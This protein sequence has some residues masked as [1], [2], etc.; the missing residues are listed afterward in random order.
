MVYV[1]TNLGILTT[2]SEGYNQGTTKMWEVE[3]YGMTLIILETLE[4]YHY[5]LMN[6]ICNLP[7]LQIILNEEMKLMFLF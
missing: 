3:I 6:Q 5:F 1:Y 7:Y 4:W 2:K